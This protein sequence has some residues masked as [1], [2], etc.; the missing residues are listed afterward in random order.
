[1]W[2]KDPETN[3]NSNLRIT[4]HINHACMQYKPYV[5]WYSTSL[6][7]FS[8]PEFSLIHCQLGSM[9][10]LSFSFF[11]FFLRSLFSFFFLFLSARLSF[12]STSS[13]LTV[14]CGSAL[15]TRSLHWLMS[16]EPGLPGQPWG[17]GKPDKPGTLKVTQKFNAYSCTYTLSL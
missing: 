2:Q 1:M 3:Q 10:F 16:Q 13:S 14:I 11:L 8:H 5:V 17:P 12:L 7:N 15:L 4:Y 6:C 9:V